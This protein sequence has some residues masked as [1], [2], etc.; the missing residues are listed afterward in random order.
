MD[1][2][3]K[4]IR[5][6]IIKADHD[7]A[8]AKVLFL[9]KPELKDIA[10][11]HCHQAIEKYLKGIIIHFGLKFLKVHNLILLLDIVTEKFEIYDALRDEIDW[12][13]TVS[14]H[15]RYPDDKDLYKYFDAERAINVAEKMRFTLLDKLG[16]TDFK[17]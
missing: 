16:M 12:L 5:K 17:E 15:V 3:V 10:I 7:L 2:I 9:Y 1:E 14:N 6:W 13:N 4:D 8:S 11:Y